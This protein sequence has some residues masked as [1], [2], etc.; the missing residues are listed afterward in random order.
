MKSLVKKLLLLI[1]KHAFLSSII[2]DEKAKQ[3]IKKV[4]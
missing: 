1:K 4:V 3:K 2:T